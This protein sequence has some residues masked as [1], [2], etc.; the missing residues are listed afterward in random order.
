[1]L[2]EGSRGTQRTM[3]PGGGKTRLR[4]TLVMAI[5]A[6]CNLPGSGTPA[7][8]TIQPIVTT[9]ETATRLP[10][11]VVPTPRPTLTLPA[12]TPTPEV[13]V[14][15][16]TEQPV[17]CRR[18]PDVGWE[19]VSGLQVGSAAEIVGKNAQNTWWYVR[20]P[21]EV[22]EFCWVAMSVTAAFGN[23]SQVPVVL[24][25]TA[26]V[27]EVTVATDV[28]YTACGEPNTVM[29][30]GTITT[31]GPTEVQY[32]WEVR[33]DKENTTSPQTLVFLS[34][35]TQDVPD[36]GAYTADCGE[37]SIR[38][39]VLKPNDTSAVDLIVIGPP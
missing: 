23:L 28:A 9:T 33:G 25:L 14:A 30:R 26:S 16:P 1:M 6:A 29:F 15:A 39:H 35:G 7:K 27:G 31:N 32:Q 2:R 24:P 34:F 10:T 38:L 13:P 19:A 3:R 22:G 11:L 4:L 37:Y 20:D 5:A 18:G 21:L 17:N 8:A 12:I 36:P